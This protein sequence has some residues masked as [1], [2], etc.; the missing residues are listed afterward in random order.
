MSTR[1]PLQTEGEQRLLVARCKAVHEQYAGLVGT[2]WN[3]LRWTQDAV[4]LAL[5]RHMQITCCERA[6]RVGQTVE[7]FAD[8]AGDKQGALRYAICR[9]ALQ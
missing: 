7:H 8:H 5:M 6:V 1:G 4:D 2:H 3:P 9:A